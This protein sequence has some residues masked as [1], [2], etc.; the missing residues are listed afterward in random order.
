MIDELVKLFFQKTFQL[1]FTHG[2]T[3]VFFVLGKVF[4]SLF[5]FKELVVVC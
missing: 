5:F 4:S 3:F 2:E 1:T